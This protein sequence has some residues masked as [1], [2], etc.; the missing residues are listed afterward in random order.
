MSETN[1]IVEAPEPQSSGHRNGRFSSLRQD[2]SHKDLLQGIL[3]RLD[4]LEDMT[5][6]GNAASKSE[7]H[8][9]AREASRMASRLVCSLL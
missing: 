8:Q 1:E 6:T 9:I 2:E 4:T 5:R 7:I 3:S